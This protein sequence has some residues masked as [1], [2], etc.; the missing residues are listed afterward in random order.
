M[1]GFSDEG[2]IAI[3][4]SLTFNRNLIDLDLSR[5]RIGIKGALK[6]FKGLLKNETIETIQVCLFLK[7]LTS[8]MLRHFLI[9]NF[10]KNVFNLVIFIILERG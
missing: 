5:N 1:N 9:V 7:Y 3:G 10:V 8:Y 4:R 6:L 2:T